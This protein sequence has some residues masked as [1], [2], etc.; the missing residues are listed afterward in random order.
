M[1]SLEAGSLLNPQEAECS[2]NRML[3]I[4]GI[5]RVRVCKVVEFFDLAQT[6]RKAK[7]PKFRHAGFERVSRRVTRY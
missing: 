2:Y 7:V 4:L 6:I 1:E 3:D 5:S